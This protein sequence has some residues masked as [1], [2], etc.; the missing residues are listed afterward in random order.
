MYALGSEH[1]NPTPFVIENDLLVT[2]HDYQKPSK[3]IELPNMRFSENAL[4]SGA[5]N[6]IASEP[7]TREIEKIGK[8]ILND[9][10]NAILHFSEQVCIWGGGQRVWGNLKR[11]HNDAELIKALRQ[12]LILASTA[13]DAKTAI[14]PG[15]EIKGLGVS[16]ASKHLR[17][18]CPE[19]FG[20][21]DDVVSQGLG[22]ALNAAGFSL[23]ISELQGLQKCHFQDLRVADIEAG[24]FVL[25][26]QIVRG[27]NTI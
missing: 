15:I 23:F 25:I 26:R 13:E 10:P 1:V 5:N 11:H 20:V 27:K 22:Y 12:W 17:L 16:F 18:L 2:I 24:L 6:L 4:R 8:N 14:L 7:L 9:I 19:K 3:V 21:L